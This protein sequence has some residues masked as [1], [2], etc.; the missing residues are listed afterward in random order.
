MRVQCAVNNQ[1]AEML[2]EGFLLLF[3]L[4]DQHGDADDD[5]RLHDGLMLIV[6]SEN[7]GRIVLVT[8]AAVQFV[9]FLFINKADRNGFTGAR[10]AALTQEVMTSSLGSSGNSSFCK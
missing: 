5:V 8:V 2:Q 6:E 10:Q 3:C 4:F 7:V 1:V 9:A